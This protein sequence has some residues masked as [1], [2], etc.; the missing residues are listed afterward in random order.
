M[1]GKQFRVCD[2]ESPLAKSAPDSQISQRTSQNHLIEREYVVV[3]QR[4]YFWAL[5]ARIFGRGKNPLQISRNQGR[6]GV[7]LPGRPSPLVWTLD[8]P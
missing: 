4:P 1:S 3:S 5:F 8:E 7:M 2:D 6:L